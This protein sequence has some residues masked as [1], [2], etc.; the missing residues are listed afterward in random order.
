L[1]TKAGSGF[2]EETSELFTKTTNQ[3]NSTLCLVAEEVGEK[4]ERETR[5][6]E[7]K[8]RENGTKNR[9]KTVA[10]AC[11]YGGKSLVYCK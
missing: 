4:S 2:S 3:K 10:R 5:N 6:S 1:T 7:R 8:K 9:I 11:K